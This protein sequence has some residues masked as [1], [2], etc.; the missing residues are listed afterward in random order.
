MSGNRAVIRGLDFVALYDFDGSLWQETHVFHNDQHLGLY[1]YHLRVRGNRV[2]ISHSTGVLLYEYSAGQWNLSPLNHPDLGSAD[3]LSILGDRLMI[4]DTQYSGGGFHDGG[5]FVFERNNGL[6]QFSEIITAS[7]DSNSVA[8]GL[9]ISQYGDQVL[10]AAFNTATIFRHENGQW[11]EQYEFV[12]NGAGLGSHTGNSVSLIGNRALV[13]A[14][15]VNGSTGQVHVLQSNGVDWLH[16]DTISAPGGEPGDHFG[17]SL[18]LSGNKAIIG[19]RG[20]DDSDPSAG[21]VYFYRFNSSQVIGSQKTAMDPGPRNDRFGFAL[22]MHQDQAVVSAHLDNDDGADSGSV[23]TYQLVGQAWQQTAKLH[24]SDAQPNDE[25]GSA[26]AIHGD[27]ILITA[28]DGSTDNKQVYVFEKNNQHWQETAILQANDLADTDFYGSAISLW[29]DRALVGARNHG[30]AGAVY[31]FEYTQGQWLQTDKLMPTEL[32]AGDFFGWSMDLQGDV[33]LVSAIRDDDVSGG[34]GAVYVYQ[35]DGMDW[36]IVDKLNA[37]GTGVDGRDF[38]RSL[39]LDQNRVVISGQAFAPRNQQL[40]YVMEHNGSFWQH[41]QL[42]WPEDHLTDYSI[43][44][45]SMHDEKIIFTGS[46]NDASVQAGAAL[47]YVADQA[48]WDMNRIIA[49]QNIQKS[50]S[51]SHAAAIFGGWGMISSSTNADLGFSAG[52]VYLVREDLIFADAL[53]Q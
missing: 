23:Y 43:S 39:S 44:K 13:G 51:F 22:D 52:A 47:L 10:I 28:N 1:G 8:F 45:L 37:A 9:G 31:V 34:A 7:T 30:V 32:E 42:L 3:S 26:V 16:A 19:A 41:S 24:A 48:G 20:D 2:L 12:P 29:G 49:P 36:L 6:W 25:F 15:A 35:Y 4:G 46:H 53:D 50:D 38:G 33:A 21:A 17:F 27:R 40:A 11:T 14:S 18:Q 5:V